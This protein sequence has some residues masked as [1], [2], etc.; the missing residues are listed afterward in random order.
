[1]VQVNETHVRFQNGFKLETMFIMCC[2][3]FEP[4]NNAKSAPWT[5]GIWAFWAV[6]LQRRVENL[7][8]LSL[9][10]GME[11][12]AVKRAPI[13]IGDKAAIIFNMSTCN[14]APVLSSASFLA[15]LSVISP[16]KLLIFS[17]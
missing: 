4:S 3:W 2:G 12:M 15:E 5:F 9:H 6:L 17:I 7:Q 8:W 16:R 13:D 10:T 14:V 1:M 11:A